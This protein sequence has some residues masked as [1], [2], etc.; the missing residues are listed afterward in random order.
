M[1]LGAA[2]QAAFASSK[3]RASIHPFL[4]TI[5]SRSRLMCAGGPPN[6]IRPIRSH[7]L[8]MTFRGAT[9]QVHT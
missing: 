6:P 8:A 7:S 5:R 9:P 2:E 3:A 1:D 4:R